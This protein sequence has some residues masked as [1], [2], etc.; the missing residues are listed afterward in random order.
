VAARDDDDGEDD[1]GDEDDKV[2]AAAVAAVAAAVAAVAAVVVL[3][4]DTTMATDGE[5]GARGAEDEFEALPTAMVAGDA[6]I[7][8]DDDD[9]VESSAPPEEPPTAACAAGSSLA[10]PPPVAMCR[11][12]SEER[13]SRMSSIGIAM[14]QSELVEIESMTARSPRDSRSGPI[15]SSAAPAPMP[16]AK[17]FTPLARDRTSG[18]KRSPRYALYTGR[19]T[20]MRALKATE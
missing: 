4:S 1:D 14:R 3:D 2:V 5:R 15:D 18:A 6:I 11:L 9:S 20:D 7:I 16:V 17:R 8:D 13:G 19:T 10:K 12:S